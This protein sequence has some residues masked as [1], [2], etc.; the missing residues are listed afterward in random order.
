MYVQITAHSCII[1]FFSIN[2]RLQICK[3]NCVRL[4]TLGLLTNLESVIV[5]KF[6]CILCQVPWTHHT[7]LQ[8]PGILWYRSTSRPFPVNSPYWTSYKRN[9]EYIKYT[10]QI[11]HCRYAYTLHCWFLDFVHSIEKDIFFFFKSIYLQF[12]ENFIRPFIILI[13][14]TIPWTSLR[15]E[16]LADILKLP[17]KYM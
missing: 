8:I 12:K 6:D 5:E 13:F 16:N 7:A 9:A 3:Q 14:A 10:M 2:G 17:E 11:P 4:A 15:V 1:Y